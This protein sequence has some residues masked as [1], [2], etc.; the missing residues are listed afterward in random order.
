MQQK[1]LRSA[2][3]IRALCISHL[4]VIVRSLA[5]APLLVQRSIPT[6]SSFFQVCNIRDYYKTDCPFSKNLPATDEDAPCRRLPR[7]FGPPFLTPAFYADSTYLAGATLPIPPPLQGM[8][9]RE[10]PAQ[11]RGVAS[12]PCAGA[13]ATG[14]QSV[15]R[16]L[17]R[18]SSPAAMKLLSQCN[19]QRTS[20]L[21]PT[22]P[23]EKAHAH[24]RLCVP[25]CARHAD[26][27][28]AMRIFDV[29]STPSN[30]WARIGFSFRKIRLRAWA[31]PHSGGHPA[32]LSDPS[33]DV[34]ASMPMGARLH[35]RYI[36]PCHLAGSRSA[37]QQ[38][39]G[40]ARRLQP[41]NIG[42]GRSASIVSGHGQLLSTCAKGP[43]PA[44][45]AKASVEEASRRRR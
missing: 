44:T 22:G 39:R 6:L 7:C 4:Q 17:Q 13:A 21:Q 1:N 11:G 24:E 10:S 28:V 23:D 9:N 29:A 32:Q 15:Q 2:T 30:D 16:L 31:S 14:P 42:A 12:L 45:G 34:S 36:S 3:R 8:P 40:P 20:T 41:R 19:P 37:V 25:Q 33:M 5:P 35:R 26:P 18:S 27:G 43:L 38:V